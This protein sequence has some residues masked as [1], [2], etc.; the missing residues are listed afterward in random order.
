MAGSGF[1]QQ[2]VT[3]AV[4]NFEEREAALRRL[5][6]AVDAGAQSGVAEPFDFD[7]FLMSKRGGLGA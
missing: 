4:R 6:E 3:D 2:I 1:I 5:R 7:A